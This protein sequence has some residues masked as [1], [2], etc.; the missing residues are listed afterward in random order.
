MLTPAQLERFWSKV[1]KSGSCWLW[2]AA[3]NPNGYGLFQAPRP[4]TKGG[5]RAP[6]KAHRL[7]WEL[8]NGPIATGMKILHQCDV[9]ACVRP[10]HLHLGT[11]RENMA[12]MKARGRSNG[13]PPSGE[14]NAASRLTAADVVEIRRIGRSQPISHTARRFGI[15]RTAIYGV[16][17]GTNWRTVP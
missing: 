12:E 7:A 9:P 4:K 13:G 1:D 15:A 2:T 16:L 8:E 5:H 6:T 11:Q 14:K 10:S 3:K 17:N